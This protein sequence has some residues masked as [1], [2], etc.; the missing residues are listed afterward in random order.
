V[1]NLTKQELKHAGK[2]DIREAVKFN[3]AKM[4]QRL[5]LAWVFGEVYIGRCS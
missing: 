2:D 4:C 3:S 1:I 5:R